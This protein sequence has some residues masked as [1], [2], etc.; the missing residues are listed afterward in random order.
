MIANKVALDIGKMF[1]I[2]VFSR[3]RAGDC[4]RIGGLLRVACIIG[5]GLF[6]V[7]AQATDLISLSH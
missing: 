2:Q 3:N 1:V 7:I 5:C 4:D 6:K